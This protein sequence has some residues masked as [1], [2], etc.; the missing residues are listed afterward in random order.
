MNT[1]QTSHKLALILEQQGWTQLDLA[2]RSG[3]HRASIGNHLG[4]LRAI[5]DEHLYAYLRAVP[6]RDAAG[7]LAA[8]LQD[9]FSSN[10]ELDRA[11]LSEILDSQS[12]RLCEDV[13]RWAP[14]L[15]PQQR[16]NLEFWSNNITKDSEL[17]QLLEIMTRRSRGGSRPE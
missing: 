3:V 8:W 14:E 6:I 5:R 13:V 7:L 2:E 17:D 10:D 15:S 1:P 16:N 4:N 9:L 11:I 12:G